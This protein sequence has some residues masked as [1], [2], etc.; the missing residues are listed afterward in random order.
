LSILTTEGSIVD[1]DHERLK[2]S[3]RL[4]NKDSKGPGLAIPQLPY[5]IF[6]V[7]PPIR[8]HAPCN[9][10]HFAPR[11]SVNMQKQGQTHTP[12]HTPVS[13]VVRQIAVI[14]RKRP[15]VACLSPDRS[16]PIQGVRQ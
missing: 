10:V 7:S 1:P 8:R 15:D 3:H 13:Q 2:G 9:F 5:P 14:G 6:P 11:K 16:A 4:G 12:P